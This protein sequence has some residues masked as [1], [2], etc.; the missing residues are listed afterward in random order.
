MRHA[1]DSNIVTTC[2]ANGPCSANAS[3]RHGSFVTLYILGDNMQASKRTQ[4]PIFSQDVVIEPVN[5]AHI[6]TLN[7]RPIAL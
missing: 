7:L 1:I 4:M 6:R 2:D 3:P 5:Q